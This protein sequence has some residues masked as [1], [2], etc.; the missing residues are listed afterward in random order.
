MDTNASNA[1]PEMSE[2]QTQD[3]CIS[4]PKLPR[5]GSSEMPHW[6]AKAFL[7]G[8]CCQRGRETSKISLGGKLKVH[9]DLKYQTRSYITG[10][11]VPEV[12]WNDLIFWSEFFERRILKV[13]CAIYDL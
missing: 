8:D 5:R 2:D 1:Q 3:T 7:G 11:S 12:N 13:N 10:D 6:Q 9:Y 4:E